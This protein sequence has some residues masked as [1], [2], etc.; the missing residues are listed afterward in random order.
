MVVTHTLY[1]HIMC[2]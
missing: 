2:F 1:L